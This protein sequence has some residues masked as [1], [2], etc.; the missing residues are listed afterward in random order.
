MVSEPD[1]IGIQT[2]QPPLDLMTWM[3]DLDGFG[4]E[5]L[6]GTDFTPTINQTFEV[7]GVLD[8]FSSIT[9]TRVERLMMTARSPHKFRS[10]KTQ[11]EGDML[12]SSDLHGKY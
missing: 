1:F 12:F 8:D 10:D 9:I 7:Q 3:P 5:D 4:E 2:S 6:F 11:H